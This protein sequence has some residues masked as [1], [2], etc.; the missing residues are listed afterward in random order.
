MGSRLS[1]RSYLQKERRKKP[2]KIEYLPL[3]HKHIHGHTH[4]WGKDG[5][6]KGGM[7]GAREGKRERK[8]YT[9]IYT[10]KIKMV[11]RLLEALCA[12]P[13]TYRAR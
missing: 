1:E 13:L 11:E 7:E 3:V 8:I 5:K 2:R 9:C 4:I 10:P 6:G 12:T